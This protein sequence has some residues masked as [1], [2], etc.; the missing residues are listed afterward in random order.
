MPIDYSKFDNIDDSDEEPAKPTPHKST[1]IPHQNGAG[2]GYPSTTGNAI[3]SSRIGPGG[4]QSLEPADPDE[5]LRIV[6]PGGTADIGDPEMEMLATQ[7][8]KL[9]ASGHQERPQESSQNKDQKKPE[10]PQRMCVKADGRKKIHTTFP[11]G[12]EMVEE[13]DEKTDVLMLRKVR[14]AVPLGSKEPEWVYEVGQAP[15]SAFDPHSDLMK[16]SNSNPI[17]LRKDTPEHFQWRIRNLAYPADVYS[18][19]VDHDKQEIVVRTSNK[20]YYKRIGIPDLARLNLKLQENSLSWKH[21]H[22]TLIISYT[23]PREVVLQEQKA[24]KEAE[25]KATVM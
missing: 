18:V 24:L 25:K 10:G 4:N 8:E 21:Q 6:Q 20:K 3:S 2:G 7:L 16:V 5:R 14:K 13:F 19:T 23:R 12:D 15:E 9:A 22:N 11:G 17:F 1:A